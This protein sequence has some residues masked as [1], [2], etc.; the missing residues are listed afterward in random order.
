MD[1]LS[2]FVNDFVV[3]SQE[4][5]SRLEGDL[6][7]LEKN[8]DDTG[9]LDSI[10]RILHTLKGSAGFLGFDQLRELS[11]LGENLLGKLRD[12]ELAL[13]PPMTNSL[14][15]L[16]DV[17]R[18]ALQ[19]IKQTGAEGSTSDAALKS[20]LIQHCGSGATARVATSA[21]PQH[22]PVHPDKPA[23]D[24]AHAKV[25]QA[26]GRQPRIA[27]PPALASGD[28]VAREN[29]QHQLAKRQAD[30]RPVEIVASPAA[31]RSEPTEPPVRVP[32]LDRIPEATPQP[33]GQN[34]TGLSSTS[35]RV[36]VDLLD[37]L[38]N[39]VGE[40]VL[41]R[42]RML[43][44][45]SASRDLEF[46]HVV[47]Q[48]NLIT[49][50]LQEGAMKTRMQAIG[51]MWQKIPRI[52][53]DVAG[54]CGKKVQLDLEGT[55]TELDKSLIEALNDP[56]LHL[57]RNAIDHGIESPGHRRAKGKPEQ[58]RLSLRALHEGGQ[59]IIEI[60]DDGAGLDVD[61]IR[62]K[63]VQR[64]IISFEQSISMTAE[65]I[66]SS[67]FRPGFSTS[68]K[69]TNVSGR[70]VGLDVVKTNIEN[71][72]GTVHLKNREQHGTTV[73]ITVPLTLAIIP[74]L[75]VTCA[76]DRYAIPQVNVV[77]LL[78]ISGQSAETRL[79][80]VVDALVL[81]LRGK[82]LPAV[83]LADLLE[84]DQDTVPTSPGRTH[85]AVLQTGERQFAIVVEG[86]VNTQEIVVKPLSQ[87]LKELGVYAGLTVTGD[88]GIALILDVLGLR[89]KAS[90]F[91]GEDSLS[92]A[93]IGSALSGSPAL[94]RRVLI[95]EIGGGRRVGI[96]LARLTRI[97][98]IPRS[99]VEWSTNREVV[100]YRGEI[101]PVLR[102]GRLLGVDPPV[103]DRDPL[104]V[105][106]CRDAERSLGLAI[107]RV[108]DIAEVPAVS[109]ERTGAGAVVATAVVLERT[110][111]LV[112][113]DALFRQASRRRTRPTRHSH[114]RLTQP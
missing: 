32:A 47:Q 68:D 39:L 36:D 90:F 34:K 17:V 15:T 8:T 100:Q 66:E 108:I 44:I 30:L 61:K 1:H 48:F 52:V 21:V 114:P 109:H 55:E 77:E 38:M 5:M 46:Q 27:P 76:G 106:V 94:D 11:H 112:D 50:E 28:D 35:I 80:R 64:G 110:T 103:P 111:D 60:S 86:I 105:I 65:E 101:M 74:A 53:R 87:G 20:A 79:E 81:R 93:K 97:C 31:A 14:F 78:E 69:I 12:R 54:Q 42:N 91:V 9:S 99:A 7:A 59:V 95:C 3:E 92:V 29:L 57:V 104:P 51:T 98:E 6:V 73:R 2:E 72:G 37:R 13:T 83:R 19:V 107:D 82:L 56:M 43:Q 75:I 45:S 63:A 58:G 40:L 85:V 70:G 88:G 84:L 49:S 96:P 26:V 102:M 67:I 18:N 23:E 62:K 71:I 22:T 33:A 4:G 41:V 25:A 89:R 16:V 10:F 24:E 113:I